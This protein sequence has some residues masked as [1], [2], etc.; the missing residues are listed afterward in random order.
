MESSVVLVEAPTVLVEGP[1]L[2]A[3]VP[4]LCAMVNFIS[5]NSRN[6]VTMT[7]V[8]SQCPIVIAKMLCSSVLRGQIT[9][10]GDMS[11]TT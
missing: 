11:R 1:M 4:R 3:A 7:A 8:R 5:S 2:L 9:P 10:R 6:A